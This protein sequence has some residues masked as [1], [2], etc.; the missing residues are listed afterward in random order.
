MYFSH[1]LA[2]TTGQIVVHGNDV[3]PLARQRIQVG[4]EDRHKGLA[5]TGLHLCDTP[6][7][8][9]DAADDLDRE[10]HPASRLPRDGP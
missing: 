4:R 1:P 10:Y 8:E 5:F 3:D 6:L 7:V 2:V 9:H